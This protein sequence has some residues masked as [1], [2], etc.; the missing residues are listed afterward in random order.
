MGYLE[1]DREVIKGYPVTEEPQKPG[2]RSKFTFQTKKRNIWHIWY[3]CYNHHYP[4]RT[5]QIKKGEDS[6]ERF[7]DHASHKTL[8]DACEWLSRLD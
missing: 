3:S 1:K 5:A 4:I 6:I 8:K 2:S 7:S